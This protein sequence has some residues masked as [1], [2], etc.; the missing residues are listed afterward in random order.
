MGCEWA[1]VQERTQAGRKTSVTEGHGGTRRGENVYALT[2]DGQRNIPD[3][4]GKKK[5]LTKRGGQ[6]WLSVGVQASKTD[7]RGRQVKQTSETSK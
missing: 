5:N 3:V 6:G 1:Q 4:G 2:T 7:K